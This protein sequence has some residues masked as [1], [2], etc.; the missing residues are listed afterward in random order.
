MSDPSEG[1]AT[2]REVRETYERIA[3][4]FA[5]TRQSPW[6]EV[7]EFLE[8]RKGEV[9]LDIGVGNG[10]HAKLLATVC[11]LVVGLDLSRAALEEALTRDTTQGFGLFPVE[12]DAASLPIRSN[13]VD[14]AVYVA[15]LHH[16]PTRA[17]RVASLAEL[18]RALRPT[19]RG[20]VSVWSV[21]HERFD[22]ETGF[23][24][25][26]DWTLPD[27]EVV[28]RFYHIYDGAEFRADV[29]D[30]GLLRTDTFES[31]G[32]WYAVVRSQE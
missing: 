25:T 11:R 1:P 22:R 14:L 19:G 20:L 26:V 2:R 8:G 23:D 10:R 16:L 28:E 31:A 18:A 29:D 24:T 12:G 5:R 9:G 7:Q 27:K 17:L 32:N 6:E 4:H 15:T 21:S 3:S 30:A 13:R